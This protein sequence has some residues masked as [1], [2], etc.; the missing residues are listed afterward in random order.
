MGSN[1]IPWKGTSSQALCDFGQAFSTHEV[2]AFLSAGQEC[3]RCL[4]LPSSSGIT[5]GFFVPASVSLKPR[6]FSSHR[7]ILGPGVGQTRGAWES[8]PLEV[9]F[10]QLQTES[11]GPI[12]PLP[13]WSCSATMWM[14]KW[15]CSP[16]LLDILRITE[17]SCPQKQICPLMYLV[18]LSLPNQLTSFPT[19]ASWHHLPVNNLHTNPYFWVFFWGNPT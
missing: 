12:P 6:A 7:S 16:C 18:L 11:G 5:K 2:L 14:Y 17:P 13:R 8:V 4:H 1:K 9:A 10:N 19:S 3:R 15:G